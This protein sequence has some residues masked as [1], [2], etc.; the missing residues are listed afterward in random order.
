LSLITD[1]CGITLENNFIEFRIRKFVGPQQYSATYYPNQMH[2]LMNPPLDMGTGPT[3]PK[4]LALAS[5]YLNNLQPCN[6]HTVLHE[7]WC[8]DSE[9]EKVGVQTA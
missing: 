7:T 6:I 3:I 5:S 1:A 2:V 9:A 8:T 4:S